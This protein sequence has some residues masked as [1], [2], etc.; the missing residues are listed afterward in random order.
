MG[1][2]RFVQWE[3]AWP[4]G[5]DDGRYVLRDHAGGDAH[6]VLVVTTLETTRRRGA[7]LARRRASPAAP[8]PEPAEVGI[9]RV[10]LVDASPV[11]EAAAKDWLARATG[12]EDTYAVI[13]EAL[14]HLNRVLRAH[15]VATA[16]F[17]VREVGPDA[18]LVTRVGYGG[19]DHVAEGRWLEASELP[20]GKRPRREAALRPQERL[21]ALLSARDAVLACEEMA[22]RARGDLDLGH[23]R[24]AALQVHLALEAAVAELSAWGDRPAL[25]ARLHDLDTRRDALSAAANEALQ[26]GLSAA[27]ADTVRDGL[28]KVEAALRARTAAG[29]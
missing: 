2:F 28:E 24:E 15:R 9:T 19:G 22:L 29:I 6:H 20:T 8:E 23:T 10:T 26:G 5:P 7:G 17:F 25:A 12:K 11:E 21:A 27:T 3:L 16:D 14:T 1:I 13:D 18:A 4:L